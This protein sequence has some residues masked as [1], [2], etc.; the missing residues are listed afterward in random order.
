MRA[1]GRDVLANLLLLLLSKNPFISNDN[2]KQSPVP[3]LYKA[4]ALLID[5][6]F[7]ILVATGSGKVWKE[8]VVVI[9]GGK[10]MLES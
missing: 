10:R 3:V 4:C 6:I 5:Q 8:A 2:T 1:T 9:C 7:F